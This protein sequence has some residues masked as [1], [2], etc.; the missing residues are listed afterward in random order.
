M[1]K[2]EIK[3]TRNKLSVKAYLDAIA[4]PVRRRDCEEIARMMSEVTGEKP[5][6]WGT[7]LVGFGSYKAKYATGRE[8]DWLI[9]G[10]ASR[11]GPISLYLTC[12]LNTMSDILRDLGPHKR[13]VGCLY[14]KTLSDIKIPVLKK[15]IKTSLKM[16]KAKTI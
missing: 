16:A 11:K 12:D 5:A 3:T 4:D 7:G 15:L 2:V 6:M 13:G 8:V 14:I 9:M 1:A 10:F